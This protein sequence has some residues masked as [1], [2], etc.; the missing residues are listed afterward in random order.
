MNTK[1][2]KTRDRHHNFWEVD[3]QVM[4]T[5]RFIMRRWLKRHEKPI[6]LADFRFDPK[7]VPWYKGADGCMHIDYTEVHGPWACRVAAEHGLKILG[8]ARYGEYR[9]SHTG[10]LV[11][12]HVDIRPARTVSFQDQ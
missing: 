9:N 3:I 12:H 10:Y 2:I 6:I 4:K 11:Q 5:G 1:D 7:K 8:F